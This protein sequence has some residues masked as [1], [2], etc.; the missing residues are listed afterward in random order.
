VEDEKAAAI[1]RTFAG[2]IK[3]F[4]LQIYNEDTGTGLIR[5][6]QI[7]VGRKTGQIMV[8]IVTHRRYFRPRRTL[9]MH[10]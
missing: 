6:L 1:I 7:R 10:L 2:L 5:H 3:S 8:I 9:Q 4:K